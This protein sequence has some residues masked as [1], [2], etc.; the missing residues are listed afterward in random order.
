MRKEVVFDV[1]LTLKGMVLSKASGAA[2]WGVDQAANR[3]QNGIAIL[4]G[5]QIKGKLREA[6]TQFSGMKA[7]LDELGLDELNPDHWLGR[8]PHR[9]TLE[10]IPARLHFGNVQVQQQGGKSAGQS[11]HRTRL[12][13]DPI[14]G[15]AKAGALLVEEKLNHGDTSQWIGKVR[16][17]LSQDEI[18]LIEKLLKLGLSW[19]TAFGGGTSTGLGRLVGVRLD[20]E[21]KEIRKKAA[22]SVQVQQGYLGL[23][24]EI[25]EPFYAGGERC[26]DN[27]LVSRE[28]ISGSM[29][30][31]ALA[32]GLSESYAAVGGLRAPISADHPAAADFPLLCKHFSEL[33]FLEARPTCKGKPRAQV[34]SLSLAFDQFGELH[35]LA[36]ATAPADALL[37]FKPDWKHADHVNAEIVGSRGKVK[38]IETVRTA[39]NVQLENGGFEVNARQKAEDSKLYSQKRI[40]PEK[41]V[42]YLSAIY[43]PEGLSE[44]AKLIEELATAI[45]SCLKGIGKGHAQV[46]AELV[47]QTQA[48]EEA[49]TPGIW[50]VVLQTPA[51][52]LDPLRLAEVKNEDIRP[53]YNE[54]LEALGGGHL[55]L[56][57]RFCLQKLEGG[58]QGRQF[59][60]RRFP[61]AKYAPT[62]LED[63]GS[64]LVIEARNEEGAAH[65]EAWRRNGLPLP[66]WALEAFGSNGKADWRSCP[67]LPENG[68]GE[69][70]LSKI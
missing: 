20:H 14:R 35:D 34:P 6:W 47:T 40:M 52:L 33:R 42:H 36:V 60:D 57:R 12:K 25:H 61:S 69:V 45:G 63:A 16:A 39:I 10:A 8:A 21:I 27:F 68:F 30:K 11:N 56:E 22:G 9:D 13:I 23:S 3:D 70:L 55:R 66:G 26:G 2:R 28:E 48:A 24:L 65:L 67:W 43:L 44:Q 4:N 50:K 31:G 5:S 17:R 15:T 7:V 37:R 19:Q 41:D 32:R 54:W 64:C 51:L 62:V 29:L 53:L 38:A 46:S 1:T 58:F 49:V 18:P 59:A